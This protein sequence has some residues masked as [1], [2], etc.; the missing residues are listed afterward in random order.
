VTIRVNGA[1][2]VCVDEAAVLVSALVPGG[3]V[4]ETTK[5]IVAV[6]VAETDAGTKEVV[7][8][9]SEDAVKLTVSAKP[10]RGATTIAALPLLPCGTVT[11]PG[12]TA[13]V[14][15]GGPVSQTALAQRPVTPLLARHGVPSATGDDVQLPGSPQLSAVQGFPS[16]HTIG[17]AETQL[18]PWHDSVPLQ[19][20]GSLQEVPS[21]RLVFTHDPDAGSQLGRW[22]ASPPVQTT[23]LPPV[24]A[25]V[26]Q[27]SVRVHALPSSHA[28]P[29]ALG[30]GLLQLPVAGSQTPATW[31]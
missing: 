23:A 21:G 5:V 2:C 20:S 7:T 10:L 19:A 4:A 31:H 24:Q 3:A 29:L 25:P 16:L 8:P 15:S 17:F 1:V 6:P 13:T 18:P 28:V 12:V 26:W 9:G 11:L 27:V 22:Q 30:A 14:K